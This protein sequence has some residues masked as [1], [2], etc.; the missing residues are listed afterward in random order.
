MH[1]HSL[2][3]LPAL[4]LVALLVT[5]RSAFA[6]SCTLQYQRA[7]N[8][9]AALGRP[10]GALGKETITVSPAATKVFSTD[11]KYEKRR[12]DGTNFYG[13]HLRIATNTGRNP[14]QLVIVSAALN[15]SAML[16]NVLTG[17]SELTWNSALLLLHPG[18]SRQ[19]KSDLSEVRCP[20]KT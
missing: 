10:D 15:V 9:W 8:M 3:L 6:Q 1:R 14:L 16:G 17:S 19:L 13:S 4:S 2:R 20:S 12:N 18:Q 11:W 5:G 7:D